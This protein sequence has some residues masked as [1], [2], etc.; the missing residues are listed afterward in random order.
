[1]TELPEVVSTATAV[2]NNSSITSSVAVEMHEGQFAFDTCRECGGTVGI[3]GL[4]GATYNT[5]TNLALALTYAAS[6]GLIAPADITATSWVFNILN[7]T[8][9]S[10]ATAVANNK[11]I[12]IEPAT[13][14]DALLMADIT[15]FAYAN[16]SAYSQVNNVNVYNYTNLGVL[17]R[18]L[19]NSV[20]T[21]VG[22]NLNIT[23]GPV[24]P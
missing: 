2:A 3:D 12:T 8:V 16:V 14:G 6:F 23:V 21:A 7:A 10:T 20:A 9:D 18:P 22:N 11:S 4:Y 24:A 13:P 19:V 5:H 1:L 17:G 15:Q